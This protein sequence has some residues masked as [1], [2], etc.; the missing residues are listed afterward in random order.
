MLLTAPLLC[1]LGRGIHAQDHAPAQADAA[2]DK[3]SA[4]LDRLVLTLLDARAAHLHSFACSAVFDETCH[5]PQP[6]PGTYHRETHYRYARLA[7]EELLE[8][9]IN[10]MP[11][12]GSLRGPYG[13]RFCPLRRL[14]YYDGAHTCSFDEADHC[15]IQP[16]R[17]IR[18][19]PTP[20][21]FGT[22]I[23]GILAGQFLR[24]TTRRR[25]AI[26]S[27]HGPVERD[28]VAL[29]A[30]TPTGTLDAKVDLSADGLFISVDLDESGWRT[31]IDVTEFRVIDGVAVGTAGTLL[32]SPSNGPHDA[33]YSRS[34][35]FRLL[36][37]SAPAT[38]Q[39]LFTPLNRGAKVFDR[40]SPTHETTWVVGE[41]RPIKTTSLSEARLAELDAA[42]RHH[43]QLPE[44]HSG[45][46]PAFSRLVQ[47]LSLMALGLALVLI[48]RTPKRAG[49]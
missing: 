47:G 9:R 8:Y 43:V 37:F 44:D 4:E 30:H 16:G 41:P 20:E 22:A 3:L 11:I 2:S 19:H 40:R 31:R 48:L 39:D 7:G 21:D 24:A 36:T 33:T 26:D 38:P 13:D 5:D 6:H 45:T 49:V 17:R 14:F 27:S 18:Y 12:A 10:R 34:T 32:H 42:R 29:T 35:R 28:I 46:T 23:H 25:W 1:V 15:T